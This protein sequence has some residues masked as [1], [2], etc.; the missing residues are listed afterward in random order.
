MFT[1]LLFTKL[2]ADVVFLAAIGAVRH[3]CARCQGGLLGLQL[4]VGGGQADAMNFIILA[5]NIFIVNIVYPLT[6][7]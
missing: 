6:P 1:T 7:L 4:H 5:A 3:G 2:R